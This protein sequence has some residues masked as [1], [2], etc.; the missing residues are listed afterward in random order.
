MSQ[1]VPRILCVDDDPLFQ[2]FVG[3]SL[4][5]TGYELMTATD[6]VEACEALERES[7]EAYSCVMIDRRMPRMDGLAFLDWLRARDPNV[8]A[9]VITAEGEKEHVEKTLRAGACNFLDKPVSA[10]GLRGA[11]ID[12]VA[13]TKQ[14]RLMA[15]LRDNV[16]RYGRYLRETITS[17]PSDDNV[18]SE[19]F[20]LPK[21]EAGGDFLV[22]LRVSEQQ[23]LVLLTDVSGHD[24]WSAQWSAYFHGFLNGSLRGGASVEQALIRFNSASVER[25]HETENL[26]IAVCALLLDQEARAMTVFCCGAP[27]PV[28]V[29]SEGRVETIRCA[30]GAPLGWFD[31]C[32]PTR[33]TV[34]LPAGAVY[35]WTDGI[36]EVAGELQASPLSD[37]QALLKTNDGGLPPDWSSE[38]NDDLLVARVFPVDLSNTS[39]A[40]DIEPLII[41]FYRPEQ[42]SDIDTLQQYW[43]NSLRIALPEVDQITLYGVLLAAREA[44]VN[45]LLHGCSE[46]ETAKFQVTYRSSTQALSVL[47]SDPGQGHSFSLEEHGAADQNELVDE[48]RGLMLIESFATHTVRSRNGADLRMEFALS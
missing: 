5:R 13:L 45:A 11:V 24:L 19:C 14:R 28:W 23:K 16:H 47:V 10:E 4:R 21:H 30:A 26:S 25:S 33:I 2:R 48:H 44:V 34:P 41:E 43:E 42:I 46:G 27:L 32:C 6:G 3:I 38:A 29:E 36:D 20:Y 22:Q 31:D 35:L 18:P 8:S 37:A 15:Q 40:R 39:P 1:T 7:A 12:A 9:I 17:L